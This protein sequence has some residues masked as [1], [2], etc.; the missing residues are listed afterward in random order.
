MKPV[1]VASVLHKGKRRIKLVFD[2]DR[3]LISLIRKINGSVWSHTMKCWHI[4][5]T[6]DSIAEVENLPQ[7]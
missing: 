5:Y 1:H 7:I 3:D 6:D 4:P 2:Y